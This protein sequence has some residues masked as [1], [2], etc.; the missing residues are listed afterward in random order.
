[1]P[2]LVSQSGKLGVYYT[3]SKTGQTLAYRSEA[4]WDAEKGYSV[5]KRTYLGRV[6]PV[7]HEIIPSS[8]KPG[9]PKENKT[10]GA[11]DEVLQSKYAE[12]VTKIQAM[13]EELNELKRQNKKL[14]KKYADMVQSV[15]RIQQQ[16][17][18]VLPAE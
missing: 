15:Q 7:T 16:I 17:A 6:D 9:R 1:M 13:T 10:P 2:F 18:A 5:P 14:E 11:V 3:N 4:R 8:G 12:P